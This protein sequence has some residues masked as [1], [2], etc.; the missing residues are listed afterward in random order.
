MSTQ[1][2]PKRSSSQQATAGSRNRAPRIQKDL[3]ETLHYEIGLHT[4]EFSGDDIAKMLST[5]RRKEMPDLAERYAPI[6]AYDTLI[7][8]GYI[9][10]ALAAMKPPADPQLGGSESKNYGATAKFLNHC[11]QNVVKVYENARCG[12]SSE[13]NKNNIFPNLQDTPFSSTLQFYIYNRSTGD[14]VE[15]S[16]PLNPHVVGI[17]AHPDPTDFKAMKCYWSPRPESSTTDHQI[18]IAVEVKDDWCK[19]IEQSAIYAR[20]QWSGA[21]HRAF[22]LV[23]GVHHKEN[24]LRFLIFHSGGLTASQ[25]L[26]LKDETG[27]SLIQKI[28]FSI[29]SWQGPEDAGFPSFTDGC[30]F[31]LGCDKKSSSVWKV[32]RIYHHALSVRGRKTWVAR[33]ALV[34]DNQVADDNNLTPDRRPTTVTTIGHGSKVKA[35]GK[36]KTSM[37]KP[38][39][40]KG[41]NINSALGR[42]AI[43]DTKQKPGNPSSDNINS[44]LEGLAVSGTKQNPGNPFSEPLV[45]GERIL[46]IGKPAL[47]T[48]DYQ[49]PNQF[50]KDATIR[51]VANFKSDFQPKPGEKCTIKLSNPSEAKRTLEADVYKA[52]R[53]AFGTP[54]TRLVAEV[55]TKDGS[56]LSNAIFLPSPNDTQKSANLLGVKGDTLEAGAAELR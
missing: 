38:A 49:M 18:A 8:Q 22:S 25:P 16:T 33:L 6:N 15:T 30:S 45:E 11:I 36:A 56:R 54:S 28:L 2:T 31:H 26:S 21:A 20:A 27:R 53:G 29:Y 19:I 55:H 46:S 44:A 23:I 41:D 48:S 1:S 52:C 40:A 43:S 4:W 47:L 24:K 13:K 9:V 14:T 10:S 7:E 12:P 37:T 51:R 3:I 34:T 50:M 35:A 5:K 32:E 42:L 17:H 39:A